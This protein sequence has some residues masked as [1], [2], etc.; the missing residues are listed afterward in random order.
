MCKH[1]KLEVKTESDGCYWVECKTCKLNG[2][3][4]NTYA[5]AVIAFGLATTNQNPRKKK[6]VVKYYNRMPSPNKRMKQQRS[7]YSRDV[8]VGPFLSE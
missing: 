3:C 7:K 8:T 6:K 2:P 1:T 5:L 4:K